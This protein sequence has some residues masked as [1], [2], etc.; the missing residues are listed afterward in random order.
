MKTIKESVINCKKIH[1]MYYVNDGIFSCFG[2]FL[3]GQYQFKPEP[4]LL[5]DY[6]GCQWY[7]SSIWG[8]TLDSLDVIN[9]EVQLP[10]LKCG[11]WL[12]FE[13]MGAYTVPISCR[14][15]GFTAPKVFYVVGE[16]YK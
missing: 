14:F 7:S 1:N 4:K 12:V 16:K 13:N 8:Q 5:D 9:E 10:Q 3:S 6:N 11:D 15:N 2:G